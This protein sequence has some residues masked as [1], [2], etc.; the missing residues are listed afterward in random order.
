MTPLV[1]TS[2]RIPASQGCTSW[3]APMSFH[4]VNKNAI[5][6]FNLTEDPQV[7]LDLSIEELRT[8][9]YT[10]HSDLGED[11][12]PVGLKLVHLNKCPILAP[13]K[14]LLPENAERLGIDREKC[15]QNLAILKANTELRDKVTEVFN[16]QRDYGE[17]KTLTINF[18]TVLPV[19]LIKLNLPLF[20]MQALSN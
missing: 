19:M 4:P 5:I 13:A 18:M 3:I 1:H 9:L 14:T 6:C 12:A 16:E 8:R 2:S 20:E 7:L 17:T 15:L 11:E 10:K